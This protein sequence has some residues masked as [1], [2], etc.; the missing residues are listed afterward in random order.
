MEQLLKVLTDPISNRIL[1]KLRIRDKLTIAEL[2][3][4]CPDIPRATLYRRMERMLAAG[5]VRIAESRKVRGQT[6]HCY[7]V[8]TMWIRTPDSDEDSRTLVN[9]SLMRIMSLYNQYFESGDVDVSRDRLFLTN[10]NIALSDAD[11]SEMLQRIFDIVDSYQ[12]RQQT[13]DAKPR[14]LFLLS[15]PG[16][17]THE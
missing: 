7:A 9:C 4:E 15:A 3:A 8:G 10:Y 1:Q 11:F 17:E 5:A 2:R 14:N 16:G 12:N 6:E 13:E